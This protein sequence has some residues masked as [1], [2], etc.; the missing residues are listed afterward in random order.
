MIS[1]T[2]KKAVN[3]SLVAEVE[4]DFARV[5]QYLASATMLE[6]TG[7]VFQLPSNEGQRLSTPKNCTA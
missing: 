5:K 6:I 4:I 1:D 2:P 7:P 3:F